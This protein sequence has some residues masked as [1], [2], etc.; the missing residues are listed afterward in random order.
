M[1]EASYGG[2]ASTGTAATTTGK[3]MGTIEE[4]E[5]DTTRRK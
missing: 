2:T 4:K 5:T 3:T 1:Q